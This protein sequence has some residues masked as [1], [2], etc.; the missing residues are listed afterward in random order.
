ML[1]RWIE[2]REHALHQRD[3]N[4][5]AQPFEWGLEYLDLAPAEDPLA[6]FTRY[7]QEA[8]T[9][10]DA[11]FTCPPATD[12]SVT[13]DVL[14]F[15]SALVTP[16]AV[17]N[18]AHA[19]IY[20]GRDDRA[21]VVLPQWNAKWED[22]TICRLLQRVGITVLRLVLPY[23]LQRKPVHL[24]RAEYLVSA[25]VGRTLQS[26]RQAVLD[27]RRAVDWLEREGYRRIGVVGTSIGSCTGFLAFTHDPRIRTGT[28]LHVSGH[29][30]DVVW[31]GISTAHVAQTVREAISLENLRRLWAPISPFSYI[32]R[33]AGDARHFTAIAGKYDLSFRYE[34]SDATFAEFDRVGV[35]HRRLILPCGHY[36]L[37]K[38]P[39]SAVAG[40]TVVQSIRRGLEMGPMSSE[41][42]GVVPG[43]RLEEGS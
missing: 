32:R 20:R 13:D 15:E 36:T 22:D 30:A 41:K 39:F 16:F 10:S 2:T 6:A 11:F 34:L 37:G 7:A 26:V 3:N 27:T 4:R 23:H 19:R 24:Q 9:R 38:L 35:R 28:F 1:R 14:R 33:L 25:N 40:Y 18:V 17:N 8:T 21:V 5:V 12:Y 42:N 43:S 29:F 31:T